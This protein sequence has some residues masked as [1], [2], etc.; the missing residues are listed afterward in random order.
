MWA[1]PQTGPWGE[2]VLAGLTRAERRLYPLLRT[3]MTLGEI[4]SAL[5]VSRNT[6]KSQAASIYRKLGVSTRE[7][8]MGV[9][10]RGEVV[11][12]RQRTTPV[13]GRPLAPPA[14]RSPSPGPR[15]ALA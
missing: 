13:L 7:A 1:D 11:V 15:A 8:L 2:E 5:Y 3:D 14:Q 12:P 4:A 9:E 6:V 10:T